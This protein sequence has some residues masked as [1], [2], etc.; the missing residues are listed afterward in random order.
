MDISFTVRNIVCLFVCLFLQLHLSPPRINLAE[1]NFAR[2][3]IDVLGRESPIWGD[4]APQ[5]P[6]IGQIAT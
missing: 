5:K 6:K 3:F 1:S 2:W 4:F